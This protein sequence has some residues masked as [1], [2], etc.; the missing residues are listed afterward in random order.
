[1]AALLIGAIAIKE[2]D[3]LEENT[4]KRIATLDK[5]FKVIAKYNIKSKHVNLTHQEVKCH[6]K[7]ICKK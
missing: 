7:Y 1:M 5:K 4:N 6:Y 2:I 3:K